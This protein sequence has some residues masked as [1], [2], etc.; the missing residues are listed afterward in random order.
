MKISLF[1]KQKRASENN[2]LED[3][4]C[5]V[6]RLPFGNKLNLHKEFSVKTKKD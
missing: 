1:P 4:T 5:G 3:N 6:P 2:L